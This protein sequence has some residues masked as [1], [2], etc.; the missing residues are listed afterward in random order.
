VTGTYLLAG[1]GVGT[2]DGVCLALPCA[3]VA[4]H[5][6]RLAVAR[7]AAMPN[8]AR[9]CHSPD[10]SDNAVTPGVPSSRAARFPRS[11]PALRQLCG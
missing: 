9:A 2:G 3:M 1:E 10:Q 11:R 4:P 7:L 8:V 6:A 5:A